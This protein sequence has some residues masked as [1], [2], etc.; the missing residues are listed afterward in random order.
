MRLTTAARYLGGLGTT[1]LLSGQG[2]LKGVGACNS[3]M[4]DLAKDDC[5]PDMIDLRRTGEAKFVGSKR[6][7]LDEEDAANNPSITGSVII[8][9]YDNGIDGTNDTLVVKYNLQGCNGNCSV[10]EVEDNRNFCEEVAIGELDLDNSAGDVDIIENINPIATS[11]VVE[12]TD[13]NTTINEL[14][15]RPM[16]VQNAEGRV[17][18]C[19]IFKEITNNNNSTNSEGEIPMAMDDNNDKTLSGDTMSIASSEAAWGVFSVASTMVIAYS[20]F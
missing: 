8:T 17:L 11:D 10:L 4:F 19:A 18:A 15:D 20:V 5:F 3:L 16:V 12:N 7:E 13:V 9:G 14:F 1:V 6:R 2:G